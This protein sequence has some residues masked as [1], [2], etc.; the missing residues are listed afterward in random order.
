M[1]VSNFA[2]KTRLYELGGREDR[3]VLVR[4][5]LQYLHIM[6]ILQRDDEDGLV[7]LFAEWTSGGD[8]NGAQA[9]AALR[10]NDIMIKE[11]VVQPRVLVP[12]VDDEPDDGVYGEDW[13]WINDFTD[14]ELS[15][16]I[17]LA[18]QGVGQTHRFPGDGG[19][20]DDGGADSE[21]LGDDA[22][23]TPRSKKRKR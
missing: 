3:T 17:D 22:K 20:V 1:G 11:I 21:V 2:A 16:L 13:C 18:M 6:S 14:D 15:E 4:E 10:L 8:L 12:D 9:G 19:A 23:P 7:D 5:S